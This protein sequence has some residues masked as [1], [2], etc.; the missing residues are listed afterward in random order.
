MQ[1]LEALDQLFSEKKLP[2]KRQAI[3][4]NQSLYA[5]NFMIRPGKPLPFG[6][7][8]AD[9]EELR[10][11]QISYKRLA[12]L[13]DYSKKGEILELINELNQ[14]KTYY[15]TVVLA[16]DGEILMKAHGKTSSD[17]RALYDVLI[18]GSNV[19]KLVVAE[20]EK[21]IPPTA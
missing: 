8:V 13:S 5:G 17:V 21:V 3:P 19:A 6:V 10:D 7:V 11:Y 9:G 16:G 18:I 2:I 4:N 12:Y 1:V 14:G 20:L 15:Y